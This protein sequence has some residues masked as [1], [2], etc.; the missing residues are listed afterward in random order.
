M[1]SPLRRDPGLRRRDVTALVGITP[2]AVQRVL[3][4]L[5]AAGYIRRERMGRRNV[6]EV[7]TDAPL[8]QPGAGSRT[9]DDALAVML[10]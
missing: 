9:V 7:I 8:P 10:D 1:L 4:D 5:E 2:A 3:N 6:Y